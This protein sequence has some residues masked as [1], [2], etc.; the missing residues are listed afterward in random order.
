MPSSTLIA[1]ISWPLVAP[2]TWLALLL[3][4]F[5]G[6]C[7]FH[8]EYFS[9]PTSIQPTPTCSP[10]P[11]RIA[12]CPRFRLSLT[13]SALSHNSSSFKSSSTVSSSLDHKLLKGGLQACLTHPRNYHACP[14]ARWMPNHWKICEVNTDLKA[15]KVNSLGQLGGAPRNMKT[16]WALPA[17]LSNPAGKEF[18][19][20]GIRSGDSGKGISAREPGQGLHCD[21]GTF[22]GS[23]PLLEF[24]SPKVVISFKLLCSVNNSPVEENL[25]LVL[26][27]FSSWKSWNPD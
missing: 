24:L 23:D 3:D 4:R 20:A 9:S 1:Q 10:G 17:F 6:N 15:F 12:W 11:L 22:S 13:L 5:Y 25:A 2:A 27:L 8:V 7:S 26:M 19:R 21:I 14:L 18:W 16:E